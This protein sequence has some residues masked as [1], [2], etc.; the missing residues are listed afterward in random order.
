MEIDDIYKYVGLFIVGLIVFWLALK[1]LRF[2]YKCVEGF[3]GKKPK[4][5]ASAAVEQAQQ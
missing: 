3:I 1:S 4:E 2:Q 5:D